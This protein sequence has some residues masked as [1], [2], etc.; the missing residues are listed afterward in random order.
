MSTELF[1]LTGRTALVT[2][3]RT[4]IG[5]ALA[6]GLAKAGADLVL[7]SRTQDVDGVAAEVAATGRKVDLVVADLARPDKVEPELSRLLAERQIDVLVNNAGIVHREHATEVELGDWRR[8]LTVNLESVFLL[9]Q[10]VGRQMLVRRHSGVNDHPLPSNG[11]IINIASLL[12]FQGGIMLPACTASKSAVA[13]LTRSLANEW[14][15]H[16]V[17]VNAIAPGHIATR[18]TAPIRADGDREAA[19]RSRIPAGRWGRPDD[20][21]G[22]AIFLSSRASD[23]VSGHVLVVDG[24]WLAR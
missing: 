9:C 14:G 7:L 1:S 8:V 5:R 3:A 16:G 15:P 13:G 24:G 2:G 10:L 23:Y 19:I 12:S 18:S 20:L 21:V 4:G 17:Q 22:A 11:K 6:I